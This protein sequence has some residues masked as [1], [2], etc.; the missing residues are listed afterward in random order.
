MKKI[1]L[2]ISCFLITS[3]ATYKGY[4]Q[5]CN[6][7]IGMNESGLVNSWGIPNSSYVNN[8]GS[9]VIEYV[10][11]K[12]VAIGGYTYTQP[13]T[14]YHQGNVY[15]RDLYGNTSNRNSYQYTGTSTAYVQKKTPTTY[16]K[17][18]CITRFKIDKSGIIRNWTSQGNSCKAKTPKKYNKNTAA[19]SKPITKEQGK[20]A[21][22]LWQKQRKAN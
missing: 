22:E 6:S 17:N 15:Q 7:W 21:Y 5:V 4:R 8:D 16:I 13:Q 14:I 12:N 10:Y 18:T 9:K 19:Y 3:C 2:L 20:K 1:L 11:Q